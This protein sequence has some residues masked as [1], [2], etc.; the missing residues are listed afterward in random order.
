MPSPPIWLLPALAVLVAVGL[1]LYSWRY[2]GRTYAIFALVLVLFSFPGSLFLA[3]EAAAWA[4]PSW[5]GPIRWL[6]VYG[7]LATG[8]HFASLVRARLRSAG[9]R[10]GVSI[11]GMTFLALGAVAGPWLLTLLPL[12]ALAGG[13]GLD[14]LGT[15]LALLALLPLLVVAA[16]VST[17][18]GLRREVVRITLDR[19]VHRERARL[20]VERH[21]KAPAP[22]PG[23]PLR[24]V[25][26]ADPHLGPWAPVSRLKRRIAELLAHD[27]D[28][29]LVTGDL[30]TMEGNATPG[31]LA[32]AL[33]PLRQAEGRCFAIFGNHD[34]EAPEEVR[35][36]LSTHRVRLLVDEEVLAQTPAGP[37]QILGADWQRQ[38]RA[39]QLERLAARFPRREDH[40]RLWLLHDPA[41]F[42]DLPD[43]EADL[44]LSGHTHGGQVGLVS[45][46]HDWTVLSRSRWP[47]H[48]LFG[49]GTNRLYVHR[50]TGFY[51]FPLRIGVPGESS[52]LEVEPAS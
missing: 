40:L 26:I 12:R 9:F 52:L 51:G 44:V 49:L 24:L 13:L 19:E 8:I 14:T 20:P 4:P 47:D 7:M 36:A 45:L 33:A 3:S 10:L 22:P 31:A 6:F 15:G 50:G 39:E 32:E 27:P 23:R 11:P 2:R 37:V 42:A 48:G 30:L 41:G 21:R 38:G 25:Q 28:L 35:S 17:S 18:L 16:S 1:P 29:V 5:R 34:H 43:G 46:G